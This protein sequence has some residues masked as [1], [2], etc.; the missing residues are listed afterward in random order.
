MQ[1]RRKLI[2]LMRPHPRTS[3][4][5]TDAG[6]RAFRES[7]AD[8]EALER[9]AAARALANAV[10]LAASVGLGMLAAWYLMR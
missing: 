1:T 6:Q 4:P 10:W 9:L 3:H 5:L 2:T 7:L 8:R